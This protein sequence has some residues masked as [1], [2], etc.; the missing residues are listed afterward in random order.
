LGS[1]SHIEGVPDGQLVYEETLHVIAKPPWVLRVRGGYSLLFP[2]RRTRSSIGAVVDVFWLP[3]RDAELVRAGLIFRIAISSELEV[4]G[5]FVPTIFS[6]DR[7]GLLGGDF[8]ELGLR[9]RWA[10]G[11]ER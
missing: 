1:I 8:T 2:V 10:T 6:R 3:G 9:W 7:I 5:T 11:V 4:R